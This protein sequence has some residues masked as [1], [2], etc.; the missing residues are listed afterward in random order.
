MQRQTK[1]VTVFGSSHPQPGTPDYEEV[2]RLGSAL[3]A[4]GLSVCTG[5]YGGVMEA[6]LRGAKEAG[7]QTLSVTAKSFRREGNAW[8]DK[9]HVVE[10]WQ[11][12]LFE[13]IRLGDGYLVCKGGTG[14]LAELAVVWEMLNKQI[15]QGKPLAVLGDFWAPVVER[16]RTCEQAADSGRA[17]AIAGLVHTVS[18]PAE[19]AD[20]FARIFAEP[21]R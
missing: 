11:E 1:V 3:A 2:R 7:G 20:F 10:T 18:T 13:L 5:G 21:G 4:Q 16:V 9:K 8:A 12:R 6:A 14:T 15:M 19:A 17:E